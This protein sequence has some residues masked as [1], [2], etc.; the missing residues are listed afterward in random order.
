MTN[1]AID[2]D[3]FPQVQLTA[4]FGNQYSPTNASFSP[5][6][7]VPAG[8]RGSPG[9]WQLGATATLAIP[10]I[11]YGVRSANHRSARALISA[12]EIALTTVENGVEVDVRSALRGAQTAFANLQTAKQASALGTE[13]SR[14]AQLQYRNGLISLT[15]ATAAEQSAQQAGADLITAHANYVSAVVRLRVAVGTDTPL[16]AVDLAAP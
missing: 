7:G 15:D 14:I 9:F 16:A 10:I 2:T 6:N 12:D 3:L 1:A 11:D 4:A 5:F 8:V 13:S